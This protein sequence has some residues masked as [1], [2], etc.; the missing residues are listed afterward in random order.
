MSVGKIGINQNRH[1]VSIWRIY[2]PYGVDRAKYIQT[3]YRSGRVT[4]INENGEVANRV[5]I[6]KS[7]IQRIKF[8]NDLNEFGSEV[9][10]VSTAY[11]G[12]LHVVGVMT[13]SDEIS[14]QDE[15]QYRFF[16]AGSGFAEIR[17]DGE[18]K[19]AL[20][21]N[22]TDENSELSIN[23]T[24]ENKQGK[25]KLNV[26]GDIIIQNQGDTTLVS[27]NNVKVTVTDDEVEAYVDIKKDEI[28]AIVIDGETESYVDIK[29]DEIK[30]V[31]EADTSV[32][33]KKDEVKIVSE[34]K[35]YLNDSTEPVLLGD[36]VV[37]F[38]SDLLDQLGRES[39]GPYPLLGNATY[40]SM[41]T[42]LE[43]LKSQLS[44]V[45]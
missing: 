26:N 31:S 36:K 12:N 21:V 17:I 5:K 27:S 44:F 15:N 28:K 11:N 25:L 35:I 18:G 23:I 41:K 32:S 7:E 2:Q 30:L 4:I 29:K 45:K 13:S 34:G 8:P 19:I 39:A 40:L 1:P 38:L 10:C 43:Q 16:K 24:S 20:T 14:D 6:G 37:N 33:I 42:N 9:V 3:S 22:G